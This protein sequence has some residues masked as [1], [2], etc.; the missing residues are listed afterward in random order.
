MHLLICKPATSL[1]LPSETNVVRE[2]P[3]ASNLRASRSIALTVAFRSCRV[4]AYYGRDVSRGCSSLGKQGRRQQSGGSSL[5]CCGQ[6]CCKLF[7]SGPLDPEAKC[8]MHDAL[9]I[10]LQPVI[11]DRA[12]GSYVWTTDGQKHL[13]MSGGTAAF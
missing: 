11:A 10:G 5:T 13:D 9:C 8:S 7:S 3:G 1:S 2:R 6:V 4:P 12:E